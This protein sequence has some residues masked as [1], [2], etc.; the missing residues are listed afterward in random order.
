MVI[1]QALGLMTDLERQWFISLVEADTPFARIT[2]GEQYV[3]TYFI[4]IRS[5]SSRRACL[6]A[7]IL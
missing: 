3:C 1:V 4:V 6:T 7:A 5:Q 2:K